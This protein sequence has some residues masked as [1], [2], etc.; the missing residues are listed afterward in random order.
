M[1]CRSGYLPPNHTTTGSHLTARPAPPAPPR[2]APFRLGPPLRLPARRSLCARAWINSAAAALQVWE[3]GREGPPPPLG[4]ILS[5]AKGG[6]HMAI[7]LSCAAHPPVPTRDTEASPSSGP[8]PGGGSIWHDPVC[9]RHPHRGATRQL[10]LGQDL[11]KETSLP[12]VY[13]LS[14]CTR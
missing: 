3:V 13:C 14:N 1:G 9:S 11:R 2:P 7:I 5:G 10:T 6:A 4:R 12:F 8:R